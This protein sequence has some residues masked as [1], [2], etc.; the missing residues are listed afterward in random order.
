M[1]SAVS[2]SQVEVVTSVTVASLSLKRPEI[3]AWG[4]SWEKVSRPS[5]SLRCFA[6]SQ[7]LRLPRV[8]A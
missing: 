3:E 8:G 2:L 7:Y 6:H 1:S 4:D 5:D